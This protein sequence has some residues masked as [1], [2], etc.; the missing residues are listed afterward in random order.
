MPK[1]LNFGSLNVDYVY[2]VEHFIRQG[3]TLAASAR[4]VFAGGKGLNQ[5]IALARAGAD[6]FHAGC[7]GKDD[8]A[9]LINALKTNGVNTDYITSLEGAS[10]HTII[11]VDESGQNCILLFGGANQAIGEAQLESAL[12][13]FSPGDFIVLQNEINLSAEAAKRAIKKEMR[14]VFN[15]SPANNAIKEVLNQKIDFLLL[16]EIEAQ[17]ISGKDD[18]AGFEAQLEALVKQFPQT[19]IVLTCG[20]H[21]V[22]CASRNNVYRHGTYDVNVVDTTAAGDTFTGFFISQIIDG[23]NIETA[24]RI[25]SLASSIAVSRAGAAASIPNLKEVLQ[26]NLKPKA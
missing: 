23:K 19:T 17:I 24:L 26:S 18:N 4:N 20:K 22:L 13:N 8:G 25:A 15:P 16:N 2:S 7:T 11:Q 10:G 3:E 5:S 12:K 1:V 14:V 9:V 21:G 6:V